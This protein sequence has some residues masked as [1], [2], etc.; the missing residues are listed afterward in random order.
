[1]AEM[2]VGLVL[3]GGGAKGAYQVGV[4]KALNEFEIPIDGI[5]GASIGALNGAILASAPTLGV[6]AERLEEIWHLLA[7]NSPLQPNVPKYVRLLLNAG[8]HLRGMHYHQY[9]SLLI[10][11][12]ITKLIAKLPIQFSGAVESL[13]QRADIIR[14]LLKRFNQDTQDG[15]FKNDPLHKVL[16]AYLD[17]GALTNGLP[18]YVSAFESAG[19]ALDIANIIKSELGVADTADSEFFH[20]QSLPQEDQRK[21]LLASAALPLLFAPQEFGGKQYTDGG[22]GGWQKSQ[23]NTPIQPLV[24]AGY[25]FIIVTH[26]SDGSLWSRS[27]FPNVTILEIRPQVSINRN[28]NLGGGT[29]DLLGFNPD[30]IESWIQQGYEDTKICV[31]RVRDAL[32]SRSQ[33]RASEC[34]LNQSETRIIDSE[35]RMQE[36]MRRITEGK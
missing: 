12:V 24:G 18:L 32:R 23:G 36:A 16:D 9:L 27:D 14:Q 29:K 31:G 28:Q 34:L 26:L 13:K 6:G 21:V 30:N 5:A 10:E 17:L 19:D 20:I 35:T 33:L 25:N 2:K 4:L 22:Q 1:M 8:L 11:S 15:L 7:E 3:S